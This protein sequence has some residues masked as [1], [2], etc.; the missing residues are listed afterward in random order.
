VKRFLKYNAVGAMGLAVK[1]G[2]L[3]A[4][5]EWAGLA[6][7]VATA[8]A[9]EASVLH[10]FGWHV[11]WTFRDRSEGLSARELCACLLRFHLGTGL[12]GMVTNLVVMRLLVETFGVHY[13]IANVAATMLA[14]VANF[15]LAEVVVFRRKTVQT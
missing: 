10:N 4:L 3:V 8:I 11:R 7:L 6:Y 12:V 13:F 14:G 9:V 1:F 15:T 2:A 5:V